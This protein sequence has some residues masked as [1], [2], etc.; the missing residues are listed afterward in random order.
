M[1][2]HEG[3]R[4]VGERFPS[5]L[6]AV[7]MEPNTGVNLTN[8]RDHDLSGDQELDIQLT[9]PPRCPSMT[10]VF[11]RRSGHRHIQK[12]DHVRTQDRDGHLQA[13]KRGLRRNQLS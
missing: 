9:E 13:K 4:E 3:Q 6:C 8:H 1:H 11:I 12:E 7:S 5:R 2:E 10:G